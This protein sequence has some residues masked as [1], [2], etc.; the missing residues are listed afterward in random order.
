MYKFNDNNQ[1]GVYYR[2][3]STINFKGHAQITSTLIPEIGPSDA[4]ESLNLPQ[5]IGVG[6][7]FRPSE[8]LTLEADVVW[9]DWHSEKQL[10]IQSS[11][12]AFNNQTLPANWK[13][14]FTF[15]TGAQYL[16]NE[17][18]ALRC[19]YA[20]GQGSVPSST[21]SP[22]VPDSDYHLGAL[23]VG[24]KSAKWS[25]DCSYE[26]IYRVRRNISGS[27]NSPTV[28]GSWDNQMHGL[29]LTY[30]MTL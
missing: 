14:G 15:R 6:Y 17:N 8:P 24:Y 21:F 3:A 5:S 22:L 18:W 2:S 27:V 29:M 26:F 23:G 16:L 19:G 1:V 30:G 12:A 28:D 25:L 7:A 9:T 11:N 10:L 13:S 4:S 20:Y